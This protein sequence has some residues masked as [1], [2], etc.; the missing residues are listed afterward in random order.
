M[1]VLLWILYFISPEKIS[2]E[3]DH[4][5]QQYMY[6]PLCTLEDYVST[7]PCDI[8]FPTLVDA[9]ISRDSSY[10]FLSVDIWTS[11]NN[12]AHL[13]ITITMGRNYCAITYCLNTYDRSSLRTFKNIENLCIL[14]QINPIY[15]NYVI[16]LFILVDSMRSVFLIY[17]LNDRNDHE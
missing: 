1:F 12:Q 10:L 8:L 14:I 6:L 7:I 2:F 13:K 11:G 5:G 15:W 4:H 9:I 16:Q 3:L 17:M